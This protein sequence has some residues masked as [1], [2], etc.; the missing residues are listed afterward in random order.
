MFLNET[1]NQFVKQLRARTNL[2]YLSLQTPSTAK[3]YS[4]SS[5]TRRVFFVANDKSATMEVVGDG[6]VNRVDPN[7]T[8]IYWDKVIQAG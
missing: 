4:T 1:D 7:M 3:C 5:E 8:T 6:D 2:Y